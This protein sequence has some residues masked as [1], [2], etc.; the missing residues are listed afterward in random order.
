MWTRM[1]KM[2]HSRSQGDFDFLADPTPLGNFLALNFRAI[3]CM[4]PSCE[5]EAKMARAF[6]YGVLPGSEEV[7]EEDY[8]WMPGCKS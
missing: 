6:T 4:T 8:A 7:K 3:F 2:A 5:K 1:Q